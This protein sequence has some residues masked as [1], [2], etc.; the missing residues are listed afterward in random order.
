MYLNFKSGQ[1]FTMGD[2]WGKSSPVVKFGLRVRLKRWNNG[3][4]FEFW[5]AGSKKNI[6]T[7]YALASEMHNTSLMGDH[8]IHIILA[9]WPAKHV[10]FVCCICP[11]R[12]L[13]LAGSWV[14]FLHR[15]PIGQTPL[16]SDLLDFSVRVTLRLYLASV[17]GT[18]TF[19]HFK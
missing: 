9:P 12:I 17:T 14:L 8:L 4:E 1:I 6:K 16:S 11:G 10:L 3:G 18:V 2:L 15:A 13:H 5:R 7:S 19:G